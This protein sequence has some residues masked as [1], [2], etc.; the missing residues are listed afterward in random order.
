MPREMPDH[1]LKSLGL[2]YIYVL[3]LQVNVN[4]TNDVFTPQQSSLNV[5]NIASWNFIQLVAPQPLLSQ[6]NQKQYTIKTVAGRMVFSREE[7]S[8][9]W[10]KSGS[11]NNTYE[12]LWRNLLWFFPY[13]FPYKSYNYEQTPKLWFYFWHN[14]LC[15]NNHERDGILVQVNYTLEMIIFYCGGMYFFYFTTNT[16]QTWF[17]I[18]QWQSTCPSIQENL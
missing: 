2:H 13:Y 10:T 16:S 14:I 15:Y 11:D 4:A 6:F 17:D 7:D 12:F 8:L 5:P 18:Y 1:H 9:S 3:C